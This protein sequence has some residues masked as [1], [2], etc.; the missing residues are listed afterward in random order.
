MWI[1]RPTTPPRKIKNIDIAYRLL[2]LVPVREM[3]GV[4]ADAPVGQKEFSISRDEKARGLI[5]KRGVS[6]SVQARKSSNSG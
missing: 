4:G 2:L 5:S 1:L 6:P 3:Q